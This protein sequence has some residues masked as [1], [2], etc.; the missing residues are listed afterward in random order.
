MHQLLRTPLDKKQGLA[1]MRWEKF[2]KVRLR[3]GWGDE[4]GAHEITDSLWRTWVS[5]TILVLLG[6]A[7]GSTRRT[8]RIG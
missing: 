8:P 6:R 5:R 4:S 7:C 3:G 1:D 2:V